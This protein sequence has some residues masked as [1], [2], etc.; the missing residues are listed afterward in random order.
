VTVDKRVTLI[1]REVCPRDFYFF[2]LLQNDYPDLTPTHQ[3]LLMV[4]L[5]LDEEEDA[6]DNIPGS[7]IAPLMPWAMKELIEERIMTI[8]QWLEMAFHLCKQRWDN[9]IEWL[10]TQ[11]MSKILLMARVQNKFNEEQSREMKKS[12]R[13]R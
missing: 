10:E 7:A 13:K 6:L 3:A 9:S 4:V 11:P 5:L 2:A 12:A 8:E 1:L